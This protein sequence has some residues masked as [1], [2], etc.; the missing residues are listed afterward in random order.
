MPGNSFIKFVSA[1]KAA[2]KAESQQKGHEG[3]DGW[4]EI[5]DWSWDIEAEA[6]HL[7]G[8]GAAV[9]KP[10]PGAFTW[11]HYYDKSSP[12]LMMTIVKGT[13]FD[14]ARIDILKQ[15]GGEK[16]QMFMQIVM[17][18][19]FITKV[20]SKGGED[21][22]VS[23]DIDMVFKEIAMGYKPQKNDGAL[24]DAKFFRYNIAEQTDATPAIKFDIK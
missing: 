12:T 3:T 17:R 10:T 2:T 6:S 4:I 7:K 21:G 18:S 22:T 19:V 16:P 8:T 13:H 1:G 20:S 9:G 15:T 11:S 24:G 5:G 14:E 23:Q